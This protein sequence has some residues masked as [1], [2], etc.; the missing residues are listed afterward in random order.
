MKNKTAE[1]I[2][3][4]HTK[5][6]EELSL[7][8]LYQ[9]CPLCGEIRENHYCKSCDVKWKEGYLYWGSLQKK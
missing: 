3:K 5:E 8:A 2:Q 6:L 4:K 9:H 7:K 1:K